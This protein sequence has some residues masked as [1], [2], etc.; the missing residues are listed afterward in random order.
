MQEGEEPLLALGSLHNILRGC[1][2]AQHRPFCSPR[3]S[4]PESYQTKMKITQPMISGFYVLLWRCFQ[5]NTVTRGEQCV[6]KSD[7][8]KF[9]PHAALP[10]GWLSAQLV[11]LPFDLRLEGVGLVGWERLGWCDY[12][13][14]FFSNS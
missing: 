5:Q 13:A 2:G 1:P 8:S 6:Y 4:T 10:S 9:Q 12:F 11:S 14:L 7:F 3:K